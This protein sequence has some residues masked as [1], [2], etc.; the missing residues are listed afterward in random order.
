MGGKRI[1]TQSNI[2]MLET[3]YNGGKKM[4]E[5]AECIG[6]DLRTVYKMARDLKEAGKLTS[7]KK[8]HKR[9][10][11]SDYNISMA[12]HYKDMGWTDRRIAEKLGCSKSSVWNMYSGY[13]DNNDDGESLEEA[14][15]RVQ[16]NEPDTIP[17]LYAMGMSPSDISARLGLSVEAVNSVLDNIAQQNAH[18][19]SEVVKTERDG[20]GSDGIG[21]YGNDSADTN[22]HTEDV[23]YWVDS[24]DDL[25][26]ALQKVIS[27][28]GKELIRLA[29]GGI[30]TAKDI[31]RYKHIEGEFSVLECA[32]CELL[33]EIS[34]VNE[35]SGAEPETA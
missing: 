7:R 28:H 33:N 15:E 35:T 3:M 4:S 9:R 12:K 19:E 1:K 8:E 20:S 13:Y 23:K 25:S 30:Y 10:V 31:R 29:N 14:M 27:A 24:C 2:E 16:K 26:V 17:S 6:C 21:E 18:T 22:E 34:E 11:A 32:I 5:I